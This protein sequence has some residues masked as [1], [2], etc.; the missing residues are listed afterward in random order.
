MKYIIRKLCLVFGLCVFLAGIAACGTDP[1]KLDYKDYT[2]GQL[3]E[4]CQGFADE[5][6]KLTDEVIEYNIT[7][8][9]DEIII[10][11]VGTWKELKPQL[12]KYEGLGAYTVEKSGKTLSISQVLKFEKR[13][14]LLTRV[15]NY[16]DME[17]TD[18]SL[19]VINTLG[20]KMQK[21]S[22]NTVM[23]LGTVFLIL[24]LI[25][26]II[27]AFKFIPYLLNRS[28]QPQP[29]PAAGM[30]APPQAPARAKAPA[31]P[32]ATAMRQDSLELA[33]VI[34]AAI[35]AETGMPADGFVVRSIKRRKGMERNK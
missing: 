25:S 16:V 21:A 17:L 10:K 32:S 9:T 8:G 29:A 13:N 6:V 30:P 35:A 23:G 4:E 18:M 31:R 5:L 7:E 22:M 1:K 34:A 19:E 3:K 12:G 24:I 15:Y 27:W 33:A 26:L 14:I 20:E 2:Y 28:K 11:L